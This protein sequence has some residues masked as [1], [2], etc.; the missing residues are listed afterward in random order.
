MSGNFI[1]ALE[2]PE[3]IAQFVVEEFTEPLPKNFYKNYLKKLQ[4]VTIPKVIKAAKKYI[5]NHVRILVVGDLKKIMLP[6]KKLGY[7]I[8][9]FNKFGQP[10]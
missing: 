2:N 10:I 1:L 6:I 9:L 5:P 4:L 8:R 3:S 7:R